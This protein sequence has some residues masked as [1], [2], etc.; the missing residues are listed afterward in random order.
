MGTFGN[1][2]NEIYLAGL[3]NVVPE[4]PADLTR[5]ETIAEERMPATAFGY[6]AGSAGSEATA[7]ANRAAF[8][9]WRL[10]PRMLRDVSAPDLAVT[11]LGTPMPAPVALA[12]VGVLEIV[13]P[14]GEAAVARAAAALG[15]PLV[16]ST[17]ASTTL[18]DVAAAGGDA[19]RWYQLYWPKDRDL[20]VS[21]LER[22]AA[23]GYGALVLT[24]DTHA[25]GWR[26]RDLDNAFL[27]FLR[28][29]GNQNYLADPVFLRAVGGAVDDE[30]R[31]AAL[32]HWAVRVREPGAHLGRP[33]LPAGALERADRPQGDPS[34][35]RCPACGRRRDGCSRRV[36]PRGPAGR[37]RRRRARRSP[38]GRRRGRRPRRGADGQRH[39]IGYRCPQGARA[40][41]QGGAARA[42]PT[43]TGSAW[44]GRRACATCSAASSRS[45]SSA[46]R[47]PAPP[48]Y[49]TSTA[50]CSFAPAPRRRSG[51]QAS[52]VVPAATRERR[53]DSDATTI[54]MPRDGS[55]GRAGEL[56]E[57]HE[58]EGAFERIEGW[59]LE[60]G[61]FAPGGESLVADLY[62]GYG[63]S[64]TIRRT[65][66]C[67][68]RRSRARFRLRHAPSGSEVHDVEYGN[69]GRRLR[70]RALAADM[71]RAPTTP[72]PS[73]PCARRSHVA[74]SIRSISCSTS[75]RRSRAVRARSPPGSPP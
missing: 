48:G 46:L 3:G 62:L 63:L 16:V 36:E 52:T 64:E 38:A 72:P 27:P 49:R 15:V 21:F 53:R 7:R 74:M 8:D 68:L 32:Q 9:A 23:S 57:I 33:R 47:S 73:R 42:V 58:A 45:S 61:F 65:V 10:V 29:V 31:L 51:E 2:Q 44:R 35:R 1:Y 70:D 30:N 13:H 12:P 75:P 28:A 41:R 59:L 6:V 55:S 37:R 54:Q 39:P 60:R 11:V 4:L 43:S 5:L 25:M 40:R 67:P 66:C 24:L 19:P 14:D 26:P 71:A 56:L 17:A 34:P 18:E 69:D 22:A 50:R 20:A